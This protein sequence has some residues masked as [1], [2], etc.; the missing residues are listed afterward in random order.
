MLY[1]FISFS[2]SDHV[3]TCGISTGMIDLFAVLLSLAHSGLFPM[4]PVIFLSCGFVAV[5]T[6]WDF[7]EA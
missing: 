7:F 4:C 3:S 5:E 6:L 2:E 1:A